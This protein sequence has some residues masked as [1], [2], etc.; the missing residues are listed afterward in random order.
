[1]NYWYAKEARKVFSEI[2]SSE[3]GLKNKGVG[4]IYNSFV[5]AHA[6]NYLSPM[7]FWD[8]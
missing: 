2:E 5:F 3:K 4:W 7:D 1:M 6:W 8:F